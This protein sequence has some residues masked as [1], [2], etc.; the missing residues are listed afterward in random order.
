MRAFYLHTAL[1][2]LQFSKT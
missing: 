1:F 2:L